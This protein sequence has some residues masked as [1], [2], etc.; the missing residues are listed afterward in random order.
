ML[1]G[2]GGMRVGIIPPEGPVGW[3]I[4]LVMYIAAPA[5][6]RSTTKATFF[7]VDILFSYKGC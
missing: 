4:A 6:A 3:L 1:T 5:R 2:T 7:V